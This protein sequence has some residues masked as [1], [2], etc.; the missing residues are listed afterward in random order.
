MKE[1]IYGSK[2]GP[3]WNRT[4]IW[5]STHDFWRQQLN[6]VSLTFCLWIS[7]IVYTWLLNIVIKD[8]LLKEVILKQAVLFFIKRAMIL[9]S[10]SILY[11]SALWRKDQ[12]FFLK[13]VCLFVIRARQNRVHSF[14]TSRW[15]PDKNVC[16]G[17]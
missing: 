9:E 11:Y 4:N 1:A 10:Y 5:S 6:T 12:K 2:C 3:H 14:W 17:F 16:F 13:R 7:V 15:M 8:S